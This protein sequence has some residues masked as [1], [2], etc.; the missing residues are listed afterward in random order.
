VCVCVCVGQRTT[1]GWNKVFLV[2]VAVR[3]TQHCWLT[4]PRSLC[5]FQD[6]N[7]EVDFG[8]CPL[9]LPT[10]FF[11]DS[12]SLDQELADCQDWLASEPWELP[13][14]SPQYQDYRQSLHSASYVGAGMLNSET[15][16]ASSL[17]NEPSLQPSAIHFLF[18]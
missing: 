13:V 5:G 14:F 4:V 8:C 1:L 7:P 10:L 17:P 18:V 15:H 2:S 12:L 6:S 3:P 16:A 11:W 9:S